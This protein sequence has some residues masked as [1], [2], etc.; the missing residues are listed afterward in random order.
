MEEFTE[1]SKLFNTQ[2]TKEYRQTNG[3]FFTPRSARNRLFE[4]ISTLKLKPKTILEPSFGS[5]EFLNDL[6][7]K[8]PTSTIYGVE[9]D[10]E[11]YSSYP[12]S[13]TLH[14][15]DFLEYK[16]NPVDLIVGNPPYFNVKE[17]NIECMTGHG[18]IY[19]LFLYK[20]LTQHL[21]KNGTLAFVLP[22]SLYNSGYYDPCR[23]Y[24]A[25]NTTIVTVEN[26]DAKYHETSQSTMLIVIRNKAS[27]RKPFI[28][29][30]GEFTYI[31]PFYKELRS[32][33]KG[34]KTLSEL[35]FVTKTGDVVWNQ[36]K[37]KL[38]DEGVLLIY[39][40]N[41]VDQKLVLN[42]LGSK[43]KQ[44]IQGFKRPP[45]KGPSILVS[46]GY[47]NTY[48]FSFA[49]VDKDTEFYG[50][51]HINV[52]HPTNEEAEKYIPKIEES[53]KSKKTQD[54]IKY[55]VGNGALSKTELDSVL[56]VFLD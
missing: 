30:R 7:V 18:N 56:P 2:F 37:D 50:E 10:T 15:V 5:G 29:E 1:S 6:R 38:A 32:L 11:L 23:K 26:L 19:I 55:F 31:T 53:F 41:I 24:I 51:N 35:G 16:S 49:V 39:T 47:G 9:K 54:F 44:Y 13:P 40:T 8:F 28:F 45:V 4:V 48:Q 3:I 25:E 46:R 20:C 42:N 52:I 22:T 43:K 21:K 33:V 34:T 36:E 12:S 14:N 17:K 27:K